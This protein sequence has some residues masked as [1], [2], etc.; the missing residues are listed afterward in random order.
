MDCIVAARRGFGH[1][2]LGKA[3]AKDIPNCRL[4][5]ISD[6]GHTPHLEAPDLP[7]AGAARISVNQGAYF[8]GGR[9]ER[10]HHGGARPATGLHKGL[11]LRHPPRMP[12]KP[13]SL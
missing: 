9:P 12:A 5:E 4:V 11:V 7:A 10:P 8:T 13:S 3:A 6:V 1:D 2:L